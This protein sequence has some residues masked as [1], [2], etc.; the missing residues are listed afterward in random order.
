MEPPSLLLSDIDW[1][2][3]LPDDIWLHLC[4]VD[5]DGS[6]CSSKYPFLCPA[7]VI[8]LSATC[9]KLRRLVTENYGAVT[10]QVTSSICVPDTERMV[11]CWKRMEAV[12][13]YNVHAVSFPPLRELRYLKSIVLESHDKT[14]DTHLIQLFE[15]LGGDAGCLRAV[16]LRTSCSITD[17]FVIALKK[18]HPNLL[19]LILRNVSAPREYQPYDPLPWVSYVS[20]LKALSQIELHEC[21][22]PNCTGVA[23][24]GSESLEVIRFHD[25]EE[26]I[27]NMLC[28]IEELAAPFDR[29]RK[30]K[31]NT[32]LVQISHSKLLYQCRGSL[33]TV[34]SGCLGNICIK[35]SNVVVNWHDRDKTC[36]KI[37]MWNM[38]LPV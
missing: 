26:S 36:Y 23:L 32:Q 22:L 33:F 11:R 37:C 14:E 9:K 35:R 28:L 19:T 7:D 21:G 27:P 3:L 2:F 6:S 25:C 12:Y 34:Y 15:H 31:T 13:G 38:Q 24:A 17:N 30:H 18:H 16:D 8:R 5:P 1:A 10:G 29:N 4:T 20:M